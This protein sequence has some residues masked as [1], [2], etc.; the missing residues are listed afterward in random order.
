MLRMLFYFGFSYLFYKIFLLPFLKKY[1]QSPVMGAREKSFNEQKKNAPDMADF[2]VED[3]KF[4][5]M[6]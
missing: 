2:D 6:K 4:K 1:Q 5:E 3:A